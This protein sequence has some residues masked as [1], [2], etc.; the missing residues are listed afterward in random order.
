MDDP[1]TFVSSEGVYTQIEEHKPPTLHS[2]FSTQNATSP[3][4]AQM[5]TKMSI[6]TVTFPAARQPSSPAFTSLLGGSKADKHN[7]KKLAASEAKHQPTLPAVQDKDESES[8]GEHRNPN[9]DDLNDNPPRN[10]SPTPEHPHPVLF[11]P[12]LGAGMPSKKKSTR[13]K[14]NLKTTTSSFVTRYQAMEGFNKHLATKT[15]DVNFMFY[16]SG[17]SFHMTEVE[18]GNKLKVRGVHTRLTSKPLTA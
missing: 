10:P 15:G 3:T 8:S 16:H 7:A 4:A 18:T 5:A 14:Q 12:T 13:S 1:L 17:K 6:V 9:A 2:Y 11:S